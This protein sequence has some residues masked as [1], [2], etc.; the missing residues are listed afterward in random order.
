MLHSK[1]REYD[2]EEHNTYNM[3]EK[4][5]FVGITKAT[6]RVFTKALWASKEATAALQDG[7]REWVT[8]LA[9]VCVSGESLPPALVDQ[10]SSGIQS[11]WTDNVEVG[12]HEVFFSNSPMGWSNNDIDLAWLEQVF[13]E[14]ETGIPTSYPRRPRQPC[15]YRFYRFLRRKSHPLSHLPPA[16]YPHASATRCGAVRASFDLLFSRT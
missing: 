2:V 11:G 16:R 7:N 15:N 9:C 6:K 3:D 5:F 14:S 1:M 13:G 10:G 8:L 4:G 12:T